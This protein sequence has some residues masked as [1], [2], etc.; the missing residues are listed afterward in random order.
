M[1]AFLSILFWR[2]S[3][4]I[5]CWFLPEVEIILRREAAAVLTYIEDSTINWVESDDSFTS[6]LFP[7]ML[8]RFHGIIMKFHVKFPAP[9]IDCRI[10]SKPAPGQLQPDWWTAKSFCIKV[11]R[12]SLPH[13][14]AARIKWQQGTHHHRPLHKHITAKNQEPTNHRTQTIYSPVLVWLRP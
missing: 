9:N 8:N 11:S 7:K 3:R 13:T 4:Q 6:A 1:T 5:G 12:V 2:F 10:F 14:S